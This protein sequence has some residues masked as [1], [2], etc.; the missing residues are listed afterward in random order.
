VVDLVDLEEDGLDDVMPDQLK[1]G[2]P[3]PAAKETIAFF[4][5]KSPNALYTSSP[6]RQDVA[7]E[8]KASAQFRGTHQCSTFDLRPVK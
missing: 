3:D 2:V 1:V 7:V 6:E 4:L 8:K 5:R